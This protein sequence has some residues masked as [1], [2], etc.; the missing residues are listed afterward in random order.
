VVQTV[1]SP[2]ES[3]TFGIQMSAILKSGGNDFHGGTFFAQASPRLQSD[4]IDQ[5]LKQQGVTA[6]NPI[7]KRWD[8]SGELGGRLVRNKL[9][10]YYS[11]RAR[12]E[13]AVVAG[14]FKPDGS[15]QANLALWT[16]STVKLSYQMS[17]SSKLL[18]FHQHFHRTAEEE[19]TRFTHY[20]SR[21]NKIYRVDTAKVE[22]QFAR[23]NKFVTL[24]YGG[25]NWDLCRTPCPGNSA[26]AFS[27]QIGTQDQLSSLI[28]GLNNAAATQQNEGRPSQ[29][30]GSLSWYKP[31]LFLGNHDFKSGVEYFHNNNANRRV[32]DRG[33]AQNYRLI[34]RN[35]VPFQ[36]SAKNNPV[37]PISPFHYLGSYVQDSWT[38]ARRLTLNLGLRYAYDNGFVPEQCR[39]AAPAPL[40]I[41]FPAQCFPQVQFKK[42]NTV[43]P[44]LFMAY[45]VFG[46]GRTA[47][48]GGWARFA[49][50]RNA[51]E[52]S[53][54]NENVPLTATFQWHDNNGNRRFD[55]GEVNL[56]PNGSD[57]VS[58]SVD[59]PGAGTL[60]YGVPNPNE[61]KPI[62]DEFSLS[63]EHEVFRNFAVR[64]TGIYSRARDEFRVLNNLR[65]YEVY[66]IP[67]TNRDPGP[68]GAL[69]T[70]DDPGTIITYW[71][72]PAALVGRAFQQPMF[73][74]HPSADQS[75]KSY[76][77]AASKR[78]ADRWQF[79]ASYSST[80][81][82]LNQPPLSDFNP[83]TEIF[84]ADHT[85]E[86]L[87]RISG[88]YTFPANVQVSANFEHRS[89]TPFARQVSVRGGQQIPSL[90]VN[91][92]PIG[93]RR[94]PNLNLLHLRVEKSFALAQR[95]RLSLRFNIYNAT[96][97][98]T[99]LTATTLSGPNFL[100]P[101][102]IAPPRLAELGAAYNF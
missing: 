86:W 52:V 4:N 74:N 28:T 67:I 41:V 87:G 80:K 30:R 38:M 50:M 39:S 59:A 66:N 34:F 2:A 58:T 82:N 16:Y 11:A 71:D 17:P 101:T 100:Q 14:A 46:D 102:S 79:M 9:W 95:H 90:T 63:V 53:L 62:N 40:D 76:E 21:Q 19:I 44:R 3:P 51:D 56:N 13:N 5:A 84:A 12:R 78:L 89:G 45:D 8:L 33:V 57:F 10:F 48:K 83:N 23:G 65:P 92:E 25:W 75:Y 93:T 96:N 1:A 29:T 60:A 88:A 36:L 85:R 94:L 81:L 98:N 22:W 43:V 7:Q 68:D 24:Q 15:P 54:A 69:G 37:D 49:H 97:V 42:G 18:F 77:F 73:F 26:P 55:P 99:V 72:Y 64:A 31:N 61:R 20:D 70:A 35:G 6:G 47:I 32:F 27:D 91:V